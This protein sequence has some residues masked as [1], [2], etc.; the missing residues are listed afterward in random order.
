MKHVKTFESFLYE[1]DG[2]VGYLQ[3]S[4]HILGM[5]N[6]HSI[7][8]AVTSQDEHMGELGFSAPSELETPK[9]KQLLRELQLWKKGDKSGKIDIGFLE[10]VNKN[11]LN[12]GFS[13][14]KYRS[15]LKPPYVM[16]VKDEAQTEKAIKDV[17]SMLDKTYNSYTPELIPNRGRAINVKGPIDRLVNDF[18]D[19]RSDLV[20]DMTTFV[21][22]AI[23][24]TTP[25]YLDDYFDNDEPIRKLNDEY[26]KKGKVAKE[27]DFESLKVT[28]YSDN[29]VIIRIGATD[30]R[31]SWGLKP[32]DA[33][34]AAKKS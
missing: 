8:C 10:L 26:A 30:K 5:V 34:F 31:L 20:R 1:G 12:M 14:G 13:L 28:I 17:I 23:G 16:V 24:A 32:G 7:S 27:E 29:V 3:I 11:M 15:R 19:G 22:S 21:T 4:F 33:L 6:D 18:E 9:V 2:G 25:F